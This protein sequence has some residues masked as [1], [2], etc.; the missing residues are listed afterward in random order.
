MDEKRISHK[1]KRTE[2]NKLFN[3]RDFGRKETH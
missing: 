3:V 2:A 1:E